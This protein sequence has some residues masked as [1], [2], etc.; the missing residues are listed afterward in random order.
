MKNLQNYSIK[1]TSRIESAYAKLKSYL[2]NYLSD[3][4]SLHT[5][6]VNMVK[7][8]EKRYCHCVSDE[9]LQFNA[10]HFKEN[11]TKLLV[12]MVS[13]KALEMIWVQFRAVEAVFLDELR[14]KKL[15]RCTGDF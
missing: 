7:R 15:T 13:L 10:A 2:C 9:K 4:Y 8:K 14:T 12:F 1:V 5:A 3:L 11:M 6:I